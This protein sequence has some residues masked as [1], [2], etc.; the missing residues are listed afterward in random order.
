MA[1][2]KKVVMDESSQESPERLEGAPAEESQHESASAA[3]DKP[4]PFRMMPQS[5]VAEG[6]KDRVSIPLDGDGNFDLSG[7]RG[8][9][10]EKADRALKAI[11][12]LVATV[13]EAKDCIILAGVLRTVT[14]QAVSFAAARRGLAMRAGTEAE[15]QA[16]DAAIANSLAPVL[17]KYGGKVPFIEEIYLGLTLFGIVR[18]RLDRLIPIG[19]N[20]QV[21]TVN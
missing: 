19:Q 17:T 13:I 20:P 1:R 7:L 15:A 21:P 14:E 11:K 16:E 10:R 3:S 9:N 5:D 6:A 12:P 8:R 18:S 2:T 4:G